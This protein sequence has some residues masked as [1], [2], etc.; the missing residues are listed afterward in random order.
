MEIVKLKP[1]IKNYLWGGKNLK[2]FGKESIED[3]IAETWELSFHPDGLSIIDSGINKGKYLKDVVTKNDLGEKVS[4]FPFFPVL[5]KLIDSDQNLSIQVHPSDEYALNNEDS[6]GKMEMWY[7]L[8]AKENS[9]LYIGFKENIDQNHFLNALESGSIL[10]QLNFYQ[11]KPG[12]AFFIKPGTIH[13]IGKGV[14]L[15]EIQQ[16]SNLTYRVYDYNRKDKDGNLRELH[17]E[18]ALKVL[19]FN[20][21]I[22]LNFNNDL[23]GKCKYFAS[24]VYNTQDNNVIET[25]EES[26]ASITFISGSGTINNLSYKIYDTF[27]IPA[28]KKCIIKGSGDYVFTTVE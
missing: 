25:N 9:G 21:Y 1:A 3:S 26:F 19:D 16:N 28:N 18:K 5:I 23:I 12:D 6:F 20:K 11:V 15:I 4:K 17:L 2:K 27:F 13:A 7:V 8:N 24:Y 22:P 14:T 10:D